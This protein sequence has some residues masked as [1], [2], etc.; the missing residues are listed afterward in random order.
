MSAVIRHLLLD[1]VPQFS[2]NNRRSVVRYHDPVG[3]IPCFLVC[4][5]LVGIHPV[6]ATFDRPTVLRGI[7]FACR[8]IISAVFAVV[9]PPAQDVENHGAR[10]LGKECHR[11]SEFAQCLLPIPQ[12]RTIQTF[13]RL[14][15]LSGNRQHDLPVRDRGANFFGHAHCGQ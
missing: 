9:D 4:P 8:L 6:P 3:R 14:F 12:L 10:P 13:V 7:I 15:Q 11:H 1:L 5:F 2:D